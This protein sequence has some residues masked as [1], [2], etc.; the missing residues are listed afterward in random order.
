MKNLALILAFLAPAAFATSITVKS[1]DLKQALAPLPQA[2][3]GLLSDLGFKLQD[4]GN[5]VFTVEVKNLHCDY[6]HR[7]AWP[8][9]HP[10]AGV[11]TTICRYNSENVMNTTKGRLFKE[12]RGLNDILN[13]LDQQGTVVFTDCAMGYCGTFAASI[14]CTVDTKVQ[15]FLKG[16]FACTYTDGF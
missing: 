7:G 8:Q 12:S 4:A 10:L 3:I 16:R 1:D 13:V 14:S 2:T 11:Q 9:E 5:G 6:R 15:Q